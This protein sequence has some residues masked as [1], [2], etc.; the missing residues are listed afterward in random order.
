MIVLDASVLIA[1]LE[2]R[3]ALHA[4]A[5]AALAASAREGP[6]IL[7]TTTLLEVLVGALRRGPEAA[8]IADAFFT[9]CRV[10]PLDEPVA[11]AAAGIRAAHPG[12]SLP[13]AVVLGFGEVHEADAVQTAE[14]RWVGISS[15][16]R[17]VGSP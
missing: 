6:R 13:D 12:L 9:E 16:V 8:A 3:D 17:L 10:E 5:T 7:T 15:R 4:P 14:R 11:R 1:H 2:R